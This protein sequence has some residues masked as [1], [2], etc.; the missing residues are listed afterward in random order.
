[1]ARPLL[2][3]S[4]SAKKNLASCKTMSIPL[5]GSC[6]EHT[7]LKLL[8]RRVPSKVLHIC[9]R[10]SF[11]PKV[12]ESTKYTILH[13]VLLLNRNRYAMPQT[14]KVAGFCSS[15][16][17]KSQG[18]LGIWYFRLYNRW[19]YRGFHRISNCSGSS[20]SCLSRGWVG[21]LA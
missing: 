12:F 20:G 6:K 10:F 18:A 13:K 19:S 1:M 3:S 17:F 15:I 16:F 14:Q 2:A 21:V 11:V 8:Y 9:L 4:P 5:P 7:K